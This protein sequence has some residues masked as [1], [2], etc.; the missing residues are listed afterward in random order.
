MVAQKRK[1][2]PLLFLALVGGIFAFSL[3]VFFTT[4]NT[5][6]VKNEAA[7]K[8]EELFVAGNTPSAPELPPAGGEEETNPR[9]RILE[10]GVGFLNVRDG[11]SLQTRQIGRVLPGDVYEYTQVRDNWYRILHP[12]LGEGWVSGQYAQE[13]ERAYSPS[14]IFF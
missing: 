14:V 2:V 3:Y 10:T 5:V 6:I 7:S 11:A 1:I 13:V 4:E 12:D 9:I 8:P